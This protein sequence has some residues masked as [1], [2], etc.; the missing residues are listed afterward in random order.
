MIAYLE[1]GE[2]VSP[3]A[4]VIVDWLPAHASATTASLSALA[5][6]ESPRAATSGGD[7]T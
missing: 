3:L 6:G 5:I 4:R 2:S 1:G 7:G